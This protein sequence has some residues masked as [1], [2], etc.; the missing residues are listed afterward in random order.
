MPPD[1][2]EVYVEV[3]RL[4]FAAPVVFILS[5]LAVTEGGRL[6]L[7]WWRSRG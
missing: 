3:A 5:G 2:R 7:R 1:W 4:V 6:A